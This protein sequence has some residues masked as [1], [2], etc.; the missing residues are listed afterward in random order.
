MILSMMLGLISVSASAALPSSSLDSQENQSNIAASM[1]LSVSDGTNTQTGTEASIS[2]LPVTASVKGAENPQWQIYVPDTDVWA[3][4][5][6][7]N[8]ETLTVTCAMVQN[9]MKDQQLRIRVKDSDQVSNPLTL[10]LSSEPAGDVAP[11]KSQ[12][13]PSAVNAA[14]KTNTAAN[15]TEA[16]T[17]NL[18]VNYIFGDGTVAAEPFVAVVPSGGSYTG[19]VV[20]PQ[21]QGYAPYIE[22]AETSASSME[23]SYDNIQENKT[24]TV[25]Y[26]PVQVSYTVLHYKQNAEDDN[27]TLAETETKTGYTQDKTGDDAKSYDGFYAL[28]Y[29]KPAI[30]ADGSTQVA[31]QYDRYYYLMNFRLNGGQGVDP[32]YGK[33]GS[34]VS[35]QDPVRP[36]YTFAGWD[37]TIPDT[38]PI[39]GGTYNAQW[40]PAQ[41]TYT[42]CYWL[43]G[44]DGTYQAVHQ[45]QKTALTGTTVHSADYADSYSGLDTQHYQHNA[46]KDEDVTIDGNGNSV[47]NVYYDR[48]ELTIHFYVYAMG[49]NAGWT[50]YQT[51]TGKYGTSLVSNGYT[52]PSEYQWYEEGGWFGTVSGSRLTFL[53]A[54][55]FDK[56]DYASG[57]VLNLYGTTTSGNNQI[58]FYKQNLDGSYPQ[59]ATN[60]IKVGNRGTF[61]FTNKYDG[62]T[63]SQYSID[64]GSTW[65]T[66]RSGQSASYS[67]RGLR[68]RFQ[69]NSYTLKFYNYNATV[70]DH[71]TTRLYEQG[72]AGLSF[73]PN[74][75]SEL[76]EGAYT[77]GGWY[78]DDECIGDPVNFDTYTMPSSDVTL[79]AKWEPAKY[80]IRI[81]KNQVDAENGENMLSQET[82]TYGSEIPVPDTPQSDDYQFVGWF[83]Q[84]NGKEQPFRF[85]DTRVTHDVDI[86]AKWTSN[87]MT[88]YTIRFETEDGKDVAPALSSS[89]LAGSTKTFNAAVNLYPD[90]AEGYFPTNR[91]HSILLDKDASKNSYVFTYVKADAIPYTVRYIEKA[92]GNELAEAKVVSDN[93]KN[94]VTEKFKAVPGYIP[95]AFQKTL[96]ISYGQTNEIDFYYTPDAQHA[97]YLINHYLRKADGTT[98]LYNALGLIGSI[99]STVS[100]DSMTV[101]G[102]T[103][104]PDDPDTVT[105]GTVTVDGLELSLYYKPNPYP[106]RVRYLEKNTDRVLLP[107]KTGTAPFESVLI[108]TAPHID[109]YQALAETQTLTIKQESG[110]SA[111]ENVLTFRYQIEQSTITY[112]AVPSGTGVLSRQKE[113]VAKTSGVAYGCTATP[114]SGYYL[115]GWYKDAACTTPVTEADGTIN[116][117]TFVPAKVNG[118]YQD[119]DYYALFAPLA[120]LPSTGFNGIWSLC[121]ICGIVTMLLIFSRMIVKKK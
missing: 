100:A 41:T 6:G 80:K 117:T 42:V 112:T 85:S 20:F 33:Y 110:K 94:V 53:D 74:Y 111:V 90:Y 8:G 37:Q 64:G 50:E 101:P 2:A 102:Y 38:I 49:W 71:E 66:A 78:T 82:V 97:Y 107:E 83:Y 73:T 22:N 32:I 120:T 47:V 23:L 1:T 34:S 51:F 113:Q 106:Y 54:F 63:V 88:T 9:A 14:A 99:G 119:A 72:I 39:G 96:I 93:K 60:T 24:T 69:R 12:K 84:N 5:A 26:R 61:Q 28:L 105:S 21:I 103:Y 44:V 17:Y 45:E 57:N 7:E 70:D 10:T 121:W 4:I 108:E 118:A 31:I 68:I 48:Q 86:Y 76:E 115:V 3:D 29:D 13:A 62:F 67:S 77:F 15:D 30:A 109:G 16:D 11:A 59:D 19:T 65:R 55:L 75:P 104:D 25:V 81:F 18:V 40:T 116:E 91:S 36:G 114:N 56:L 89:G 98:G 95:D 46:D 79:F 58:L 35:I 52:W 43:E 27:Y 92:T 87:V